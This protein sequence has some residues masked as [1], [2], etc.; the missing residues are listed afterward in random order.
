MVEVIRCTHALAPARMSEQP[1]IREIDMLLEGIAGGLPGSS[2]DIA[3]AQL[4]Q[5]LQHK[6]PARDD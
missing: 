2:S 4:P 1:N 6:A 3:L 5:V